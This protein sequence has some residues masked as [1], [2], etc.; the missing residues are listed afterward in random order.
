MPDRRF[1]RSLAVAA[2]FGLASPIAGCAWLDSRLGGT[3]ETAQSGGEG[4][5]GGTGIGDDSGG[6][7]GTGI[8]GTITAFGSIVVNGLHVDYAPDLPV[9][10]VYGPQTPEAFAVGQV[11]AIEAVARDGALTA[12]TVEL[13]YPVT[14]P[15]ERIDRAAGEMVVLGQRVRLSDETFAATGGRGAAP[16]LDG[17]AEGTYVDV[18][19]LRDGDVIAAS[20]VAPRYRG[21]I[22]S[23]LG[24]VTA[25]GPGGVAI[26]GQR[27]DFTNGGAPDVRVG[28]VVQVAGDGAGHTLRVDSLRRMPMV[29]FDGR[30]KRLSIEGYV[31]PGTV[32]PGLRLG[33]VAVDPATPAGR[34]LRRGER[35][36][37]SGDVEAGGRIVPQRIERVR[38]RLPARTTAPG[39]GGDRPTP[40]TPRTRTR[41]PGGAPAVERNRPASTPVS[42][43]KRTAGGDGRDR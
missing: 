1:I 22:S 38:H 9:H 34:N 36:I 33:G 20:R 3:P 28:E 4:G 17:L 16:V 37:L 32:G 26:G 35:V 12:R 27:V 5:I 7:G 40:G 15:V 43:K 39:A 31:A 14:G 8:V 25:S 19:G 30:M 18:S 6:I 11:V 42:R 13:Q 24:P 23:I 2:L 29:P 21:G 41:Q 10:S